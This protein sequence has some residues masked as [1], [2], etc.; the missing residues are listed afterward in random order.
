MRYCI[1]ILLSIKAEFI[2]HAASTF[3]RDSPSVAVVNKLRR[4][5]SEAETSGSESGMESAP[6]SSAEVMTV[7]LKACNMIAGFQIILEFSFAF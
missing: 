4:L 2:F 3:E 6:V 7:P 5:L 1:L